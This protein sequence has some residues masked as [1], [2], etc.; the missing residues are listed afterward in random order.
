MIVDRVEK[1]AYDIVRDYSGNTI[2]ILCVLKGQLLILVLSCYYNNN[3]VGGSTF[4]YDLC[5]AIR[6]F[7][8]C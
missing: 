7:H 2:H 5:S 8:D 4:F 1:L 3:N 6:R